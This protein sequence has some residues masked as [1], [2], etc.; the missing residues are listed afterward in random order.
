M[1]MAHA[2]QEEIVETSADLEGTPCL[3]LGRSGGCPQPAQTG[4]HGGLPSYAGTPRGKPCK[5]RLQ[6]PLLLHLHWVFARTLDEEFLLSGD[7]WHSVLL[8]SLDLQPVLI[9][10]LPLQDEGQNLIE[11]CLQCCSQSVHRVQGL[12]QQDIPEQ[13][14]TSYWPQSVLLPTFH[15]IWEPRLCQQTHNLLMLFSSHIQ[16]NVMTLWVPCEHR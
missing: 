16:I 3:S 10:G 13:F 4:S 5:R 7:L 12:F 15:P 1:G 11:S 14:F 8:F 9:V 6:K 2:A